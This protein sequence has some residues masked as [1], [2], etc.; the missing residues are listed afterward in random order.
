MWANAQRD[1]RPAEY[2]WRPLF[3]AAKFGWRP[4]L[5]CRAVTL[6]KRETRWNLQGCPKLQDRSQPL[7]GRSSPYC[8]DTWRRYCCLRSFFPI[9]DTCLIWEDIIIIIIIIINQFVTR[10]MP[11]SQ[12]LRRGQICTMVPKWRFLA[13][14]CVLYFQRAAC[15]TFQTCIL[16]SH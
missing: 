2:R 12:I 4:L 6:P 11:V 9:V 8:G 5:E 7:V 1:G 14:F 10:Q 15:S 13:T 16:N 3:N